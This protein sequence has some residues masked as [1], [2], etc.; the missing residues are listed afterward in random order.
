[1]ARFDNDWEDAGSAWRPVVSSCDLS[2]KK[3][4]LDLASLGMQVKMWR[5][6]KRLS[7]LSTLFTSPI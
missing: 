5:Y 3:Y 1:M 6:E 2:G 7:I 4:G